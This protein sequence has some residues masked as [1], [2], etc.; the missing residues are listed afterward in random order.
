METHRK[1]PLSLP[2]DLTDAVVSVDGI[3][4]GCVTIQDADTVSL[5]LQGLSG[6][7]PH[8]TVVPRSSIDTMWWSKK[9]TRVV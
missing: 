4:T 2:I 3:G 8:P 6:D 1:K 7:D 5:L 9:K